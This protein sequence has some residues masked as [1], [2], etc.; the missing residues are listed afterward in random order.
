MRSFLHEHRLGMRAQARSTKQAGTSEQ[1]NGV[2]RL[3]LQ[4]KVTKE[5]GIVIIC[6]IG[7]IGIG[8]SGVV[9]VVGKKNNMGVVAMRRGHRKQGTGRGREGGG[10]GRRRRV[11]EDELRGGIAVFV[12]ELA[13]NEGAQAKRVAEEGRARGQ[14]LLQHGGRSAVQKRVHGPSQSGGTAGERKTPRGQVGGRASGR[15]S[16]GRLGGGHQEPRH[17]PIERGR[18]RGTDERSKEHWNNINNKRRR[19]KCRSM[20][21]G[22]EEKGRAGKGRDGMG[23]GGREAGRWNGRSKPDGSKMCGQTPN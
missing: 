3:I 2:Q 11:G 16:G 21:K 20:M 1:K 15:C 8:I 7:I 23:R 4:A 6:I 12:L 19:R 22:N 13:G 9:V 14:H 10:R 5:G 18:D 17:G